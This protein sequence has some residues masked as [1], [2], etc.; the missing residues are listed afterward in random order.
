MGDQRLEMDTPRRA[1]ETRCGR[2]RRRPG[3]PASP[4]RDSAM[5]RAN[6]AAITA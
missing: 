6:V 4:Y 1:A 5:V 3:R 2:G